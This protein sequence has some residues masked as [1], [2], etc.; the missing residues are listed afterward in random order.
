M[1]KITYLQVFQK[2]TWQVQL[3]LTRLCYYTLYTW[4]MLPILLLSQFFT[5]G[6]RNSSNLLFLP[7]SFYSWTECGSTCSYRYT[8]LLQRDPKEFLRILQQIP[9][10]SQSNLTYTAG[11]WNVAMIKV[12]KHLLDNSIQQFNSRNERNLKVGRMQLLSMKCGEK[13]KYSFH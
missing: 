4:R 6:W 2:A 1:E 7:L 9:E 11:S 12:R 13:V 10:G 8:V 3:H 5:K